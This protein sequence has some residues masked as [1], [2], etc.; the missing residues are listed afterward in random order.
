MTFEWTIFF[1]RWF[2]TLGTSRQLEKVLRWRTFALVERTTSVMHAI[3]TALKRVLDKRQSRKAVEREWCARPA[4][5]NECVPGG[6]VLSACRC[7][8]DVWSWGKCWKTV[9]PKNIIN[10]YSHCN[11]KKRIHYYYLN[12][13][14]SSSEQDMYDNSPQVG[15]STGEDTKLPLNTATPHTCMS[16]FEAQQWRTYNG[17]SSKAPVSG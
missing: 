15:M 11:S 1:D 8:H 9:G 17:L 4:G 13:H 14:N 10:I 3:S 7:L 12:F 16:R 5:R 2:L 6:T